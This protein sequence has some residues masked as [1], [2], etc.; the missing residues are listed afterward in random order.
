MNDNCISN[1][2][3]SSYWSCWSHSLFEMLQRPLFRAAFWTVLCR[4]QHFCLVIGYIFG[5]FWVMLH[6]ETEGVICL[7]ACPPP[8]SCSLSLLFLLWSRKFFKALYSE[9][10]HI[11][12][13]TTCFSIRN[14]SLETNLYEK[15]TAVARL[16]PTVKAFFFPPKSP[17]LSPP[18]TIINFLPQFP[19]SS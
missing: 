7:L 1:S 14:V 18:W 13:F 19:L 12:R 4:A 8:S 9:A 2:Y 10:S 15:K 5:S 17:T 16:I 11:H 6:Q 3:D